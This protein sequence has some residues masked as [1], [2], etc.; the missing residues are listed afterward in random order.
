VVR[1]HPAAE[2]E[3]DA[4]WPPEEKVAMNNAVQK[5]QAAGAP[6]TARSPRTRS[7]FSPSAP[8]PR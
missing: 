6:S 8:R 7:S 1:W 2:P 5:L 3:R 4:S